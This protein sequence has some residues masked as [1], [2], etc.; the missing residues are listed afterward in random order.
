MTENHSGNV[1][2]KTWPG[3]DPEAKIPGKKKG[4]LLLSFSRRQ[5]FLGMF[6]ILRL[7]ERRDLLELRFFHLNVEFSMEMLGFKD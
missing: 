5:K 6:D 2:A 1:G 3:K 7:G 4:F